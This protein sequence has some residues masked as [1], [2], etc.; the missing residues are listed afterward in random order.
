MSSNVNTNGYSLEGARKIR[1]TKGLTLQERGVLN[2]ANTRA[3]AQ[4][5]FWI[6]IETWA[7]ALGVKKRTLQ[8]H[9]T[10]LIEKDLL[11]RDRRFRRC[12]LYTV[13][14]H[15]TPYVQD[16]APS[17][18]QKSAPPYVQ[19]SAQH[20]TPPMKTSSLKKEIVIDPAKSLT[21]QQGKQQ[22]KITPGEE[23]EKKVSPDWPSEEQFV[24]VLG[25]KDAAQVVSDYW[26]QSA[27]SNKARVA[28]WYKLCRLRWPGEKKYTSE[29]Q[30]SDY[31]QTA[32]HKMFAVLGPETLLI[33]AVAVNN[34]PETDG[35]LAFKPDPDNV[36]EMLEEW[37]AIIDLTFGG[38]MAES[39]Y[40]RLVLGVPG[41]E[42]CGPA[43][44]GVQGYLTLVDKIFGAV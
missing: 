27:T 21:P 41:H 39:M 25:G 35:V 20:K 6:K 44:G 26:N 16:S 23:E 19:D 36:E 29:A 14:V 31:K 1:D 28:A 5:Q 18:V 2:D 8:T 7:D 32:L 40:D 42:N 9:I 11:H 37:L 43:P 15:I 3:N 24:T 17:Y 22:I 13:M 4:H 34:W 12:N 38:N 10:S 33:L 30:L